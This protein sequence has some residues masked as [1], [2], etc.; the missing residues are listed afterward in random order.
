[1]HIVLTG[2]GSA[3]HVIPHLALLPFY[4]QKNWQVSYIGTNGIEKKIIEGQGKNGDQKI[5]FLEIKAGKL[6]RYF[7]VKNFTDI[8]NLAFGFLQSLYYLK[9]IRADVVFSKGGFVSVP[10]A[11][12]AR[13]WNIPVITHES[14]LTP[15]LANR[16]IAR[17]ASKILYSFPESG[18]YMPK[19]RSLWVGSPLRQELAQG[20]KEQG[21]QFCGFELEDHRPII[22]V[23]GGSLGAQRLNDVLEKSLDVL[24]KQFR[25]IHITGEGKG[26]PIDKKGYQSFEFV[27]EELKDIFA[28]T[29]LVVSRSGSNAIFEFLNLKKPM[30]LIPLVKGSRGDQVKNAETFKARGWAEILPEDKLSA[31]SLVA[32]VEQLWEQ[33]ETVLRQMDDGS[34]SGTAAQEKIIDILAHCR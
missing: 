15:G 20:N 10:V 23:M 3:G 13:I 2:G 8:F 29:D 17:F 19:D 34:R 18:R 21:L 27:G 28:V 31:E 14:D 24:L 32:A 6:R 22:L 30:L 16:I 9:K 7:S 11:M 5:P 12:A 4:R 26:H 1:M 25:V 33:R